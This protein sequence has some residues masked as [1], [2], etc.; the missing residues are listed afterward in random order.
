MEDERIPKLNDKD[1]KLKKKENGEP[2]P[3]CT[4]APD[5]EHE[6]GYEKDEP[7]D[8]ARTGELESSKEKQEITAE[9]EPAHY[10]QDNKVH[11]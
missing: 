3:F 7:C 8:D 6:R 5:P 11:S 10:P 9:K 2:M 1:K 4:T